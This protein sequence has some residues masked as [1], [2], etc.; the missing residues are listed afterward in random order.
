MKK[1]STLDESVM[2]RRLA[3]EHHKAGKTQKY[4][5]EALQVHQSTVS[6]WL[7]AYQKDGE[8]S[9][10][11]PAVGG[12]SRYLTVEQ[13]ALLCQKLDAGPQSNGFEGNVWL[14]KYVL[15]LI[16]REFGVL[17]SIRAISEVLRRLGYSWQTPDRVSYRQDPE[18]V[19]QWREERLPS[20]KKKAQE[21]GYTIAYIDESAYSFYPFVQKT[22]HKKGERCVVPHGPLRGGVQSISMITPSGK[23]YYRL[24]EQSITSLE[25]CD[26]L[27]MLLKRFRS[28]KLLIIWDGAK[29]HDN[30]VIRTFLKEEANGRIHLE[31]LPPYSPQLNADEQ[32]H[33]YIKQNTF[34]NRLFRS[35][36]ELKEF[37]TEQYENLK[38]QCSKVARFFHHKAVGFYAT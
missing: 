30:E 34:E 16:E 13:E 29:T 3:I 19:N 18:K 7:T 9:L 31:K 22:Y 12:S 32:V 4:I 21:E 17:Y 6:R 26:F 25:V 2:L 36:K 15:V 14:R 5:A 37:V 24:Y 35:L 11:R 27:R 28:T 23:L 10:E 38:E 33:G 20:I 1:G 8:K